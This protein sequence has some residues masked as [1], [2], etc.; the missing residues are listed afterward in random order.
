M[1]KF[2]SLALV[3]LLMCGIFCGCQAEVKSTPQEPPVSSSQA[4]T[5]PESVKHVLYNY[6]LSFLYG[7]SNRNLTNATD[8]RHQG[9][10]ASF[11]LVKSAEELDGLVALDGTVGEFAQRN[12]LTEDNS[13][14]MEGEF[15]RPLLYSAGIF[16]PDEAFFA[17]HKLLVVDICGG[18]GAL[19]FRVNPVNL[20]MSEG[21]ATLDVYYSGDYSSTADM[22]GC[23]CL[24]P[25]PKDCESAEVNFI[26]DGENSNYYNPLE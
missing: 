20:A 12:Q 7:Y 21:H 23:L 22:A 26:Y 13:Y 6:N 16:T 17:E 15:D 1:K 3:L 9:K 24:I 25:L 8:Q 18:D 10:A 4:E 5:A 19:R 2:I 11:Y 14:I